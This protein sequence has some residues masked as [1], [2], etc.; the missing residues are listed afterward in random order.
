MDA[1]TLEI[2]NGATVEDS[3]NISKLNDII[4]NIEILTPEYLQKVKAE[5]ITELSQQ[6]Y[7]GYLTHIYIFYIKPTKIL[8]KY[9][10]GVSNNKNITLQYN[11]ELLNLLCEYY[12]YISMNYN[13]VCNIYG[14]STLT[15]IDLNCFERW[16]KQES[17]RPQAYRLVKR[18]QKAYETSLENGAQSGKNPVG[19]IATLNHRFGWSADN[20]P[21]LTVNITRTKQEILSSVDKSLL[22]ENTEKP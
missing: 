20:K 22:I 10:Q 1:L 12:I 2:E 6:Q 18:L 5:T 7:L 13:K 11:D 21:S 16:G 9:I 3:E 17:Q 14:F 4:S 19:F 15:G 8:Y